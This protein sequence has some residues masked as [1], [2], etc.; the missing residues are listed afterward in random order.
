MNFERPIR[1]GGNVEV[2]APN[3]KLQKTNK[4]QGMKYQTT[5]LE[6]RKFGH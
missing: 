2:E 3:G 1:R 5:C 6:I 4:F